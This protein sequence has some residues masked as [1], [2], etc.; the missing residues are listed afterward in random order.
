MGFDAGAVTSSLKFD[1]EEFSHNFAAV[2]AAMQL[3]PA[4]LIELMENPLLGTIAL[5]KEMAEAGLEA[6]KKLIEGVSELGHEFQHLGLEAT[7]AGVS[8]EFLENWQLAG[9]TVE[10][11]AQ[12]I[13]DGFK[14]INERASEAAGGDAASGEVYKRLGISVE[15]LKGHLGDSEAIATRV[16]DAFSHLGTAAEQTDAGMKLMGRAGAGLVPLLAMGS[17]GIREMGEEM[18]RLRGHVTEADTVVGSAFQRISLSIDDAWAG[19][20]RA[21]TEPILQYFAAHADELVHKISNLAEIVKNALGGAMEGIGPI[22]ERTLDLFNDVA[23]A[24]VSRLPSIIAML[25]SVTGELGSTFNALKPIV[26]LVGQHL[27]PDLERILS[28]V[29]PILD[30]ESLA[31]NSIAT[32]LN[33]LIHGT[34]SSQYNASVAASDASWLRLKNDFGFDVHAEVKINS[35]DNAQRLAD[36]LKP[37]LDAAVERHMNALGSHASARKVARGLGGRR[38]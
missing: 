24:A 11:G 29:K 12:Q 38:G 33:M 34:D 14:L 10:I 25:E 19:I 6:V 26:E 22:I 17:M 28:I 18:G 3:F 20:K 15:F 30:L 2:E 36:K 8:T 5:F 1:T 27:L 4:T 32:G 35:D 9:R 31:H 16:A 21:V 37:H 13:S 23:G 7:K